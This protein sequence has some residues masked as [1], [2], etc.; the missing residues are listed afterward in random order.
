MAR[1]TGEVCLRRERTGAR[2]KATRLKFL[3]DFDPGN[4]PRQFRRIERNLNE[5]KA[6][7]IMA[8]RDGK[9]KTHNVQHSLRAASRKKTAGKLNA[10]Q[11]PPAR[12]PGLQDPHNVPKATV[13]DQRS[14][15]EKEARMASESNQQSR[16]TVY[17]QVLGSPLTVNW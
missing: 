16:K 4:Q 15:R 14:S 9:V 17:K 3:I 11:A 5:N 8:S 2:G 10:E 13:Q 7:P 6:R 12:Q 1:S